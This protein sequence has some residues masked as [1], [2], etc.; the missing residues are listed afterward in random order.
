MMAYN[1]DHKSDLSR[2]SLPKNGQGVRG[3][4]AYR[5]LSDSYVNDK[6]YPRS[7]YIA[8]NVALVIFAVTV[9]LGLLLIFTPLGNT[10]EI[11]RGEADIL[12][13]LEFYDVNGDLSAAPAEGALLLDPQT[14]NVMGEIVKI[15]SRP[16]TLPPTLWRDQEEGTGAFDSVPSSAKTVSVT[17]A[18]CAQYRRGLGYSVYGTRIAKGCSYTVSFAGSIA[19]GT[20]VSIEK[21]G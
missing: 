13:T 4:V 8:V 6:N 1:H 20:C 3:G 17:V 19:T 14:G 10:W 12:Y 16:Y 15:T 18:L 9:L 2:Q 21:R 7:I 5:K 11:G